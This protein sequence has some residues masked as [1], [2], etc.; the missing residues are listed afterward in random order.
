MFDREESDVIEH[1]WNAAFGK[2]ATVVV[3]R[4]LMLDGLKDQRV[5]VGLQK[6]G[7][8]YSVRMVATVN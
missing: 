2:I 4:R 5:V 6:L 1:A 7:E 3:L 8:T